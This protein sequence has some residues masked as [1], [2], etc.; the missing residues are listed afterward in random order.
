MALF[1]SLLCDLDVGCCL[2]CACCWCRC[3]VFGL[4]TL[5][6]FWLCL[7]FGV[8]CSCWICL[9]LFE[10]VCLLVWLGFVVGC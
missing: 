7:G 1:V 3:L 8:C 10:F 4:L 6:D 5:C 9:L 2:S